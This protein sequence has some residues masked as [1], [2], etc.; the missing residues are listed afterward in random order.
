MNELKTGDWGKNEKGT[1]EGLDYIY[2][3]RKL[4]ASKLEESGV[5]TKQ[6]VFDQGLNIGGYNK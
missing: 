2:N 5:L 4:E 3:R 6:Q 1:R